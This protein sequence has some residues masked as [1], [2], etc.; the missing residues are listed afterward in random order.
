MRVCVFVFLGEVRSFHRFG[1]RTRAA[2]AALSPDR[3]C[4]CIKPTCG[5]L[6][7]LLSPALPC[8][9]LAGVGTALN[10]K[11][12]ESLT[13]GSALSVVLFEVHASSDV[14]E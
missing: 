9:L 2:A 12:T 11:R 5:K 8:E 1:L 4:G 3:S 7:Y 6:S 14:I 13:L 10:L